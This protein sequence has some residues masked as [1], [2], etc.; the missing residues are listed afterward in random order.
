[1]MGEILMMKIILIIRIVTQ[2]RHQNSTPCHPPHKD[3][4]KSNYQVWWHCR[5]CVALELCMLQHVWL[6]C[7]PHAC[8]KIIQ[9]EKLEKALCQYLLAWHSLTGYDTTNSFFQNRKK[10]L[11]FDNKSW[12]VPACSQTLRIHFVWPLEGRER[13]SVDQSG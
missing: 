2:F 4:H 12:G 3:I 5:P 8:T 11:W 1:M 7:G 6:C 13:G 9:A 10:S